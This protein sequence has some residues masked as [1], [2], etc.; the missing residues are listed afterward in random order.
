MGG[1]FLYFMMLVI[2]FNGEELRALGAG[3]GVEL[4]MARVRRALLFFVDI[5]EA[6]G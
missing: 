5:F 1:S 2:S 4:R 3:L 6:L